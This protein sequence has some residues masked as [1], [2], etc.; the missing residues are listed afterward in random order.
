MGD[1]KGGRTNFRLH[2]QG[3]GCLIGLLDWLQ[4]A[5]MRSLV[6]HNGGWTDSG[7]PVEGPGWLW[8]CLDWLQT[9]CVRSWLT[10]RVPG[11]NLF[12]IVRCFAWLLCACTN[13]W[14]P[15]GCFGDS[16]GVRTDSRLSESLGFDASHHQSTDCAWKCV[17]RR[18]LNWYWT[19]AIDSMLR[20]HWKLPTFAVFG[21]S[22]IFQRAVLVRWLFF[23]LLHILL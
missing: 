13:S 4:S 2:V 6:T 19:T 21:P 11:I 23:C 16:K 3:P 9:A 22:R 17:N 14:A 8:G 5:C 15:V 10:L 1:S 12:C 20:F 18:L 7:Q